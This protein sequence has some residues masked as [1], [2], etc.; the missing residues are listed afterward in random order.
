MGLVDL[1]RKGLPGQVEG[2]PLGINRE[3][4][5]A[6]RQ[7]ALA[8]T[9]EQQAHHRVVIHLE[10][11]G[12]PHANRDPQGAQIEAGRLMG[13]IGGI[14]QKGYILDRQGGMDPLGA[15]AWRS[16]QQRLAIQDCQGGR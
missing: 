13:V 15:I 10:T 5:A 11:E 16:T 12:G 4:L 3:T 1:V 9:G 14:R 8:P 7:L 2:R 6:H